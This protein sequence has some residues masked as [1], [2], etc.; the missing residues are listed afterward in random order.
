MSDTY[1]RLSEFNKLIRRTLLKY[2]FGG[3]TNCCYNLSVSNSLLECPIFKS[4]ISELN[5]YYGW[6]LNIT[7][8]LTTD[9]TLHICRKDYSDSNAD[10]F[11]RLTLIED[12]Y[13]NVKHWI[14]EETKLVTD[15]RLE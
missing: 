5:A 3:L 15:E 7:F 13:Y 1:L 11:T 2:F 9:G 8:L 4:S 12:S 6:S 14:R 10:N